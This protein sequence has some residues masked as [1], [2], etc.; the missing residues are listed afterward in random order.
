MITMKYDKEQMRVV[1]RA[2]KKI[3]RKKEMLADF[4]IKKDGKFSEDDLKYLAATIAR[5]KKLE[6][7]KP[8]VT[9]EL[10][11]LGGF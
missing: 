2:S 4:V 10:I 7:E 11:P 3:L 9:V 1:K 8:T 5:I 6:S